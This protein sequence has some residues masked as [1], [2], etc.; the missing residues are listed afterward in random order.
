MRATRRYGVVAVLTLHVCSQRRY[1]WPMLDPCHCLSNKPFLLTIFSKQEY[2]NHSWY[3]HMWWISYWAWLLLVGGRSKRWGQNWINLIAL[4]LKSIIETYWKFPRS[5]CK[6]LMYAK[7]DQVPKNFQ[8]ISHYFNR[9]KRRC[10]ER[11]GNLKGQKQVL[12]LTKV[13]KT[14]NQRYKWEDS[15]RIKM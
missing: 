2:K 8:R 12:V 3:S 11:F 6:V 5:I 15:Y 13:S 14:L 9:G 1:Q 4:S 10:L 7:F